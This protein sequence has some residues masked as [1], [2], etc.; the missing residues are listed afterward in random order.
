MDDR[1]SQGRY[2]GDILQCGEMAGLT[3]T[4]TTYTPESRIPYHS[5]EH[6][7]FCVVLQGNYTETYGRRNR[8]CSAMTVAFHPPEEVHSELFDKTI[9]RSFNVEVKPVFMERVGEHSDILN[10]PVDFQGGSL[11]WLGVRLYREFRLMD[12]VS[13]LAIEGLVLEMLAHSTRG[14]DRV[15]GRKAGGWLDR[16]KDILHDRFAETLTVAEM[17][18]SVGVHPVHL[19]REFLKNHHCTIGEYVRKLRI[20]YACKEISTSDTSLA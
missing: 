10:D 15:S 6:A 17:A 4:E 1:L 8:E 13:P 7:Y 11:A 2:Y 19:A 14:N 3:L 12:K 9:V 5:H 18:D 20:D 16:A